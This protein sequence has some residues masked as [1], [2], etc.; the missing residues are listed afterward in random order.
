MS[1]DQ[2]D[3][4]WLINNAGLLL[5]LKGEPTPT[6]KQVIAAHERIASSGIKCDIDVYDSLIELAAL[7]GIRARD[8][9]CA[10]ATVAE[11]LDADVV[12]GASNPDL[13]TKDGIP[14]EVK[15]GHFNNGAL[16]QL[17][18]YMKQLNTNRGIACG[19]KLTVKLPD[20]VSFIGIKFDYDAGAYKITE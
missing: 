13:I 4:T 7:H 17:Q 19:S 6:V 1:I 18:R 8:E 12:A 2:D 3:L 11:H 5:L 15:V 10:Y 14:V 20:G 9:Y 16:L